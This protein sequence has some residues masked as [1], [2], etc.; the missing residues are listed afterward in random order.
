MAFYSS[1]ME[2]D[3]DGSKQFVSCEEQLLDNSKVYFHNLSYDGRLIENFG[4]CGGI[5]KGSKIYTQRL[6]YNGKIIK[7]SDS[8]V[9]VPTKS[10]NFPQMFTSGNI[11]KGLF[12]YSYYSRKR[13][14][15]SIGYV[16]AVCRQDQYTLEQREGLIENIRAIPK[17]ALD[18]GRFDM[19]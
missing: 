9:L 2:V 6:S 17:C 5:Q 14:A 1:Y 10:C 4:V 16:D 19:R 3:E 8:Y 12:P 13:V 11:K 7:T 15:H 18:G